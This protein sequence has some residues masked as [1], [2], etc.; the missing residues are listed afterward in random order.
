MNITKA[1]TSTP[2][3]KIFAALAYPN[4]R[5]WFVGQMTS[6]FGTW[7]QSTAQ[8]YLV[9]ELTHSEAYLGYVG[10][11]SGIA[12]WAF[13]MYGGV[14][15]DRLPRRSLIVVTQALSMLLAF[16]LSALTFF[17][18]V[19]PWH[20][21]V[22]AFL[23]G[24]VNSF[25]APARQSFVLEMVERHVLT[26]AIALNSTM[27]N[28]ATAVGPAVG[29]LTYALFGPGWC[30]A[31]NGLSFVAVIAAL[32]AMRLAPWRP[33]T[34]HG[35]AFGDIREGL[36]VVAGDRRILAVILLLASVSLFGMSFVTLVPAWAVQV[37]HGDARV[38]GLLQ[39]AR[40][41][42]ALG[43]ALWIAAV[44]HRGRKGRTIT[45]AS[46]LFPVALF[47]L[48]LTR[49]LPFSLLALVAVGAT[50]ITVNNLSNAFVQTL[51]PDAV[52]GRVMSVYMLSFFGFMPI[53]ALLA[54]VLAAR[55]GVPATV[56]IGASG[57]LASAVAVALV[58]PSVRRQD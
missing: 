20:I 40:G 6:L 21:V 47:A 43:A 45:A 42:G 22:L 23:L 8:G 58:V 5:L 48:S 12:T 17:H 11:A 7:M 50:N 27:F 14:I 3:R 13:T 24:V 28:V 55:I 9:Y 49:S 30:F 35:S 4:Y 1:P 26:N 44:A 32:L 10:F 41:V 36:R 15:A 29:G 56:M 31:I 2:S 54:G 19:A 16:A 38:N 53:G 52:R 51:T 18:V 57:T 33:P 34:R 39:S 37:L 25:D 46:V